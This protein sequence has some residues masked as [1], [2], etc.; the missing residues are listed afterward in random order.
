MVKVTL[1]PAAIW[2]VLAEKVPGVAVELYAYE[3][4][5][6]SIVAI[7]TGTEPSITDR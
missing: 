4:P 2:L 7:V 1:C 5:S 3:L 6:T